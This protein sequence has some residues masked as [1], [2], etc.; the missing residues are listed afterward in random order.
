MCIHVDM[1]ECNTT[2]RLSNFQMQQLSNSISNSIRTILVAITVM[3]KVLPLP[4]V[5]WPVPFYYDTVYPRR[6]RSIIYLVIQD[7]TNLCDPK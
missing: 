7:V 3:I 6:T 1:Q 5:S 4:D 2:R